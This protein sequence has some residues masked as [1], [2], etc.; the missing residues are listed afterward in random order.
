MIHRFIH[1]WQ[2]FANVAKCEA[3][4]GSWCQDSKAYWGNKEF[5]GQMRVRQGLEGK[6]SEGRAVGGGTRCQGAGKRARDGWGRCYGKDWG[7]NPSESWEN[8]EAS[9]WGLKAGT[10]QPDWEVAPQIQM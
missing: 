9:W 8:Q 3:G 6:F 1:L 10:Q 2:M 7:D 5:P 4:S